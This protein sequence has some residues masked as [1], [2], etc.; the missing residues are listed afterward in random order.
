[1]LHVRSC[2]YAI[3]NEEIETGLRCVAAPI[4]NHMNQPVAAISVSAPTARLPMENIEAVAKDVQSC[5][6]QISQRL[7]YK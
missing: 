5:A 2:G 4:F 1:M 7:G 6:R 3:D